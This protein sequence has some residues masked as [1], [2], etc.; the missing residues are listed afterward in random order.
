[1]SCATEFEATQRADMESFA[2]YDAN[3]F[4]AVHHPEAV[5]INR[6]GDLARGIE[7]IMAAAA[8][9]F[10]RREAIFTW[11]ELHRF[12]D[13][14]RTAFIMYEA[15]YR[16]EA[17]GYDVRSI[18]SVTYVHERGRWLAIADQGT[19]LAPAE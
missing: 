12:V 9:H 7:Q 14:C 11:N 3:A 16:I 6:R 19:P 13:G 8:E 10:Q 4:R 1:M 5:T 18:V 2:A 15:R 17:S